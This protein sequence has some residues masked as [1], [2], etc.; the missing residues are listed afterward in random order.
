VF[1][2]CLSGHNVERHHERDALL[3]DY[4]YHRPGSKGQSI[5]HRRSELKG[6]ADA[7]KGLRRFPKMAQRCGPEAGS[8][9]Q[10]K[11]PCSDPGPPFQ[12]RSW[13]PND[14]QKSCPQNQPEEMATP[15]SSAPDLQDPIHRPV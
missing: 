15:H 12:Q 3:D 6:D 7:D 10:S 9:L 8:R 11:G 14:P 5:A 1:C 2:H 4:I 13:S